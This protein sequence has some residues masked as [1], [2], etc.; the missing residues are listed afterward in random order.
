MT[1][2]AWST[3]ALKNY[4]LASKITQNHVYFNKKLGSGDSIVLTVNGQTSVVNTPNGG[5]LIDITSNGNSVP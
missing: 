1:K 5:S 3:P 2:Q 4:G